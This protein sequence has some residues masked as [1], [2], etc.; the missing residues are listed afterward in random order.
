MTLCLTETTS[1]LPKLPESELLDALPQLLVCVSADGEVTLLNKSAHEFFGKNPR[2]DDALMALAA[3]VFSGDELVRAHEY[4]FMHQGQSYH[5]GVHALPYNSQALLTIAIKTALASQAASPW[6]QEITRAAGVMAAML[7]HE[8]KNPLSSIRGAAQLLRDTISDAER[9]LAQLICDETLRIRDLLD[10]VE[11]FSDE[12]ELTFVPLNIHE[13][14]QY[15]MQVARAGFAENIKFVER[16]DPSLPD[17]LSQRD[18]LVQIFLNI[19][20]NASEALAGVD[21]ATI[22]LTTSYQNNI[23][24]GDKKLPVM[25]K[26]EDNGQGIPA[27]I[28]KKLF[29]PLVSTKAQGRGLGLSV[30]AKLAL[31]LGIIVEC[32]ERAQSGAGFTIYL[33]TAK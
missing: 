31:D 30:V 14:L 15:T 19:I 9:P 3:R 11:V 22:T 16:Y 26:I 2:L 18:L 5:A 21:D 17:V 24:L 4:I 12:R 28:R 20:K 7:A 23:R 32:D 27:E 25:V 33:P 29:E 13:A 8:V 1:R 10:Q 6:K